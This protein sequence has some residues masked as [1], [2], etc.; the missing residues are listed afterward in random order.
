MWYTFRIAILLCLVA[1][2]AEPATV[3]MTSRAAAIDWPGHSPNIVQPG[4]RRFAAQEY[5]FRTREAVKTRPHR[6]QPKE[7]TFFR[8][9]KW[10]GK[11]RQG[12][13]KGAPPPIIVPLPDTA[14]LLLTGLILLG[15][16]R[17]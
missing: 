9:K 14:F 3:S 7:K 15:V 13:P 12:P 11:S 5:L 2:P 8:N 4:K 1:A 16:R 6:T 10:K 17:V